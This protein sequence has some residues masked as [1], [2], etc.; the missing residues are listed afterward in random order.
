MTPFELFR[1][2]LEAV[3]TGQMGLVAI[4]LFSTGERRPVRLALASLAAIFALVSIINAVTSIGLLTWLRSV[5]LVLELMM[6]PTI[7]L[8]VQQVRDAPTT[9]TWRS[10]GHLFP[11][12]LG[13]LLLMGLAVMPVDAIVIAVHGSYAVA[14]VFSVV[15]KRQLYR[16]HGLFRF[17][18]L[19]AGFFV[20]LVLF[21]MTIS[22]E[23]SLGRDFR[24]S[25]SYIAILMAMLALSIAIILTALRNPNIL[26]TSQA[27]TKYAASTVTDGEISLILER[28]DRLLGE[29]KLFQN[30]NLSLTDIAA[31]IGAPAKHVS[32]AV[33]DKRG[34]SVPALINLRR[35]E[36]AAHELMDS[37]KPKMTVTEIMTNAGFGSKSAFQREFQR[38][39]SMPPSEYRQ[40]NRAQ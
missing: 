33:N 30:P 40:R 20:S 9:I 7:Y 28:L 24:M 34:I 3:I 16:Q 4:C 32:Q 23:T 36:Y 12:I 25:G 8:F 15:G 14:T 11:L 19:F 5:N 21:R 37:A 18:V 2:L 35:V 10:L 39:Y 29:E 31:R 6:G 22:M 17:V 26:A 38:R 1:T 13:P 27:F